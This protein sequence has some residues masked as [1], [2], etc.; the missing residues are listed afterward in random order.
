MVWYRER[1][2]LCQT[3]RSECQSHSRARMGDRLLGVLLLIL[4]LRPVY[5][6]M[7]CTL[8]SADFTDLRLRCLRTESPY[9]ECVEWLHL[10]MKCQERFDEVLKGGRHPAGTEELRGL[11]TCLHFENLTQ[12]SFLFC[13]VCW[14]CQ[15]LGES[16]LPGDLQWRHTWPSRS[17]YQAEVGGETESVCLN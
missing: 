14:K 4:K 1:L 2:F 6:Q 16:F 13:A 7:N 5:S 3:S 17:W 8:I 11:P 9:S 12:K 15:V 10:G